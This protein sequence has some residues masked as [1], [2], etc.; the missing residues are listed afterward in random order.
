LGNRF[1]TKDRKVYNLNEIAQD[2]TIR[3][4]DMTR[5]L[6]LDLSTLHAL[7]LVS[8]LDY[9]FAKT[10]GDIFHE[11][12]SLALA[13]CALVSK[14][15]ADGYIC[16][17]LK[18]KAGTRIDIFEQDAF[19]CLPDF[20]E[21]EYAMAGA[22]MVGKE[23]GNAN[24][25]DKESPDDNRSGENSLESAFPLVLDLSGKL[26]LSR[27]YDFQ[28][29]LVNNLCCR[30]AALATPMDEKIVCNHL[31]YLFSGQNLEQVE[32][33]KEAVKKALSQKFVVISGGP[34]TGKTHITT[35]IKTLLNQL[36]AENGFP[37]PKIICVAPT[38]KA[39]SRLA[40]GRTIHSVLKP[41]KGK[42]GFVYT[43]EKPLNVDVVIVDEASMIDIALMT[44]LLEAI[45]IDA[46]VILLGDKNQLS[47]VQ[48][49][50]VFND[51]C[52]VKG[53]G[54]NLVFLEYNFRSKGKTGIENLAR[55]IKQNDVT[56]METLLSGSQYPDIVFKDPGES[57]HLDHIIEQYIIDG[58]SPLAEQTSLLKGLD[59]LDN[60]RI[61]CAHNRGEAG[62]LQINHLCEKILRS[63]SNF[64]ITGQF[65]KKVV[66][67]SANDY[68]RGLFNGDTGIVHEENKVIKAGFKDSNGNIRQYRYLDLPAHETAYAVTIH[69]SQG[70]EF[71]SVLIII[72][73]KL[74]PIVT[75]QLLYTGVT[76]AKKRVIIVGSLDVIKEAMALTPDHTS[77]VIALL[78]QQ[79]GRKK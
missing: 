52:Q 38:G 43:R 41:L 48:A 73:D 63:Q 18:K 15:L 10:M 69:K 79:L 39:A 28:K 36:S 8:H 2:F 30:V 13:S 26:Y 61:L 12:R 47:P 46:K 42:T 33:Q 58:Y 65:F 68:H 40:D 71:D 5:Q 24:K 60:F 44:R 27:Y 7:Q 19:I 75:R 37:F 56:A 64:D 25:I 21:W 31:D 59:N 45:P 23:L 9:Y 78:E 4:K 1:K 17:D 50:A 57:G 6:K 70:S 3:D 29:R 14:A 74:S 16:L 53:L 32:K 20:E 76:R 11:T 55:T 35:M 72:P 62:T 51:I 66:M 54:S 67:I 77:N 34:G 49:G 22:A